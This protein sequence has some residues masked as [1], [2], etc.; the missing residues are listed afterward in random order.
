MEGDQ[1]RWELRRRLAQCAPFAELT[2]D[3]GDLVFSRMTVREFED[4]AYLLRQGSHGDS[5]Y[6]LTEGIADG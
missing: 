3:L 5:L 2:E 6:V 4:G 1:D